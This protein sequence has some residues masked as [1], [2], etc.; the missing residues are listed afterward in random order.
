MITVIRYEQDGKFAYFEGL[1]FT[2]DDKT[3]YYFN[4]TIRKR[5]H[6]YV[7]EY[8]NGP[9]P[10][11]YH[12]HHRD[13]HKGNNN[14]ENLSIIKH[15]K[16]VTLHGIENSLNIE[17]VEWSRKNLAENARPAA[18][19]W[20]GSEEGK[21]W[22]RAHYEKNKDKLHATAMFSCEFCDKEFEALDNGLN[23]FCSN[24]C[25][26][27]WRR[28]SGIDDETRTCA[29]CGKEFTVNKYEKTKCCS[30]AC[31]NRLYPRLP[32]LRESKSD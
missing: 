22:H 3:G 6:R 13:G 5:L 15:S 26:S 27:A 11:G 14:I 2:K 25:K 19:E 9:I 20:H 1:K 4:S 8:F 31:S 18:S 7:W 12:I 10:K 16:H 29:Y 28:A 32:Q 24:R 17:W 21:K 23:R 30:K